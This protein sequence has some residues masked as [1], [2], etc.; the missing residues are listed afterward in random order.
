MSNGE[1]EQ[2]LGVPALENSTGYSQSKAVAESL[3]D[4]GLAENVIAMCF[5][6]TPS[7]TGHGKGVCTLMEKALGPVIFG[8]SPSYFGGDPKSTF[9]LQNGV[10]HWSSTRNIQEIP[11]LLV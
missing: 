4:W 1:E 5:D 7:N 9:R 11:G 3:K 8:L 2:L 6:T 10:N